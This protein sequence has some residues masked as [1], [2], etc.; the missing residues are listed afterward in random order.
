MLRIF[1]NQSECKVLERVDQNP[2]KH[3]GLLHAAGFDGKSRCGPA[4][5]RKACLCYPGCVVCLPTGFTL[6]S[7]AI[8][9]WM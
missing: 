2:W 9:D 6:S 3:C 4:R 5:S 7:P 1:F 8:Q